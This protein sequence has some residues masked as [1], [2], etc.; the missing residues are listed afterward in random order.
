MLFKENQRK[1]FYKIFDEDYMILKTQ[2][3]NHK[4]GLIKSDEIKLL[5]EDRI[6]SYFWKW[7]KQSEE[8]DNPW[9]YINSNKE[10]N[11]YDEIIFKYP[12]E[13]K[14]LEQINNFN[15]I[16]KTFIRYASPLILLLLLI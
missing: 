5:G 13:I 16:R 1:I 7:Y 3:Y 2:T 4:Q 11:V 9:K 10:F 12:P 14:K 8:R 6:I 15:I